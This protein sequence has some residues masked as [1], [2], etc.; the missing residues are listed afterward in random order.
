MMKRMTSGNPAAFVA[1]LVMA[2][3]PTL[4]AGDRDALLHIV[5][6]QC[7][8]HWRHLHDPAPCA[9]LGSDFAVLAD[10][11]G[12]A[13]YLLIATRTVRGIED[14]IVL[15]PDAPNYFAA[16]WQA[17]DLLSAAVGHALGDDVVGLA[18]NSALARG[19]DQLH[20]HIECQGAALH[21]A[22]RAAGGQIGE[23]WAPLPAL[24]YAYLARRVRGDSLDGTNPFLLLAEGAPGA[25]QDMAAYTLVVAA[26]RFA[27]GAGFVLLAGRTGAGLTAV[28]PSEGQ[29]P[30]G[31]KLLD[32][33]C[34]L[35]P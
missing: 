26:T 4:H 18:I 3:A 9:S 28:L 30:P 6:D 27:D 1:V 20:I 11:K 19:Q 8:S 7:L 32:S 34:A 24:P 29:V 21:Q 10:R 12:G 2:A 35:P 31:E 17:R 25:R 16:A 13:H 15:A 14:P 33:R 23:K 5:Q 22:L